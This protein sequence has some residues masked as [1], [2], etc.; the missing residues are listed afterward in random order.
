M[1]ED[2]GFGGGQGAQVIG[3]DGSPLFQYTV[4]SFVLVASIASSALTLLPKNTNNTPLST[5]QVDSDITIVFPTPELVYTDIYMV[6][7]PYFY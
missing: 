3:E 5:S 6:G 7:V 4:S 1:E 2:A